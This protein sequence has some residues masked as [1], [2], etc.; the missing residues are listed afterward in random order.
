MGRRIE[1]TCMKFTFLALEKVMNKNLQVDPEAQ[2]VLKLFK[3]GHRVRLCVLGSPE[4]SVYEQRG[5]AINSYKRAELP[6]EVDLDIIF[7]CNKWIPA[8]VVGKY[9][10]IDSY[11]RREIVMRGNISDAVYTLAMMQGVLA[12]TMSSKKYLKNYGH[13]PNRNISRVAMLAHII[14]GRRATI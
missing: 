8:V 2:E 11:N 9:S 4:V 3:D 5:N 12:Y 13:L 14:F 10:L 6:S 7:K 1:N